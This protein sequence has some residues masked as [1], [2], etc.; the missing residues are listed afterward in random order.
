M[1]HFSKGEGR[2]PL[3]TEGVKADVPILRDVRVVHL[4]DK[5][6]LWRIHWVVLGDDQLQGE[7]SPFIR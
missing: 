4:G 2:T 1:T 3:V 6:D 7:H 5:G